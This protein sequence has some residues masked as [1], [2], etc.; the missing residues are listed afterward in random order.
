MRELK[1][2]LREADRLRAEDVPAVVATIVEIEGSSY[3]LEGARMLV[4]PDG[5]YVGT[6]SGGCLEGEVAERAKGVLKT[7]APDLVTLEQ[8]EGEDPFGFGSGCGG[9]IHVLLEP[10]RSD[11]DALGAL[12]LVR[13][14][15]EHRTA[16]ALATVYRTEGDLDS[17]KGRHLLVTTPAASGRGDIESDALRKA[18]AADAAD[19]LRQERALQTAYTLDRGRVDVMIEHVE[20]P[21]RLLIFGEEHDAEPLVRQANLLGWEPVV[22]GGSPVPELQEH[23][24]DAA[25]HVALPHP[26]EVSEELAHVGTR[27]AAVVMSHNYIRDRAVLRFLLRSDVGYVGALGARS[28][29]ERLAEDFAEGETS[30]DRAAQEAMADGR[31]HAPVGLDI[32]AETPEEIALSV[33]AEVQ[34]V[35]AGASGGF[36]S[37]GTGRIHPSTVR[38]E[39]D[40]AEAASA[41]GDPATA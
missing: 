28:R 6:I 30:A 41:D 8:Q 4:R 35:F 27:D 20:P 39:T 40:Q 5:E 1:R 29:L 11:D 33:A 10:F 26:E 15:M 34:T 37:D 17:E 7:G 16:G 25:G 32:G 22:V 3:R 23:F 36:L 31:L 13:Q 38:P 9:T 12:S 21:L 24:P 19:V 14:C 2:I 18:V